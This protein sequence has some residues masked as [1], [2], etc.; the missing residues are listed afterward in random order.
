MESIH[1]TGGG[2]VPVTSSLII[3]D[4]A[5]LLLRQIGLLNK[6]GSKQKVVQAE[7]CSRVFEKGE[8]RD[9]RMFDM[10][11]IRNSFLFKGSR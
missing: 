11:F 2:V 10:M 9:G 3:P 5:V 7:G 4:V 1:G 8:V 6:G